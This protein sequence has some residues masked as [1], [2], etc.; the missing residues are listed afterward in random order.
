MGYVISG[1]VGA[2]A[3]VWRLRLSG[4]FSRAACRD[5]QR[6]VLGALGR[7]RSVSLVVDLDAVTEMCAACIDTLL[8]GYTVALQRGHGFSVTNARGRA[9]QALRRAGLIAREDARDAD[10]NDGRR[11]RSARGRR[12]TDSG[13]AAAS[14]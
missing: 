1:A 9:G 5:L 3:S 12:R 4:A 13:K 2:D 10:A 7:A 14:Q 8:T 6:E 11:R